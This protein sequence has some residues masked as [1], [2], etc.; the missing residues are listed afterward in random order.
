LP[1][2]AEVGRRLQLG[3]RIVSA[4]AIELHETRGAQAV[5]DLISNVDG[6]AEVLPDD[7]FKVVSALQARGQRVAMTGGFCLRVFRLLSPKNKNQHFIILRNRHL[8]NP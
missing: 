3:S 1:I 2:A 6:F 5:A 7:K 8:N 4:K